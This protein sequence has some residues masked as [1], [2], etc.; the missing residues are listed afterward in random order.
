MMDSTVSLQQQIFRKL[1]DSYD[2]RRLEDLS[3]AHKSQP[4]DFS[5]SLAFQ[6]SSF[7]LGTAFPRILI[8]LVSK[9]HQR[10]TVI[11][12]NLAHCSLINVA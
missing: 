1:E 5:D 3:R 4:Q 8:G 11:R 2:R 12:L 6:V 9:V 10:T 7:H